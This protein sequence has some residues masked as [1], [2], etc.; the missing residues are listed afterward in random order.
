MTTST[1]NL[2]SNPVFRPVADRWL[3]V[4]FAA[5]IISEIWVFTQRDE[6][7]IGLRVVAT[8]LSLVASG[9]LSL[10]RTRPALAFWI[11]GIAVYGLI[12]FGYPSDIYQWTN[13]IA[14]YSVAAHGTRPQSWL[15]LPAAIAGP[16]FYFVRF[17]FMGGPALAAFVAAMWM[18]GWLAGRMA[19]VRV[20]ESHLRYERDLSMQLAQANQER[21][22][23]EEERNLIARELHDIIGHTVNVMVVHA[24]AGR[25]A[26]PDDPEAAVVA[27][28]TIEETGRSALDE[29]DRVLAVLR[30]D[31]LEAARVPTPGLD[32]LPSLATTFS[33]AG[34]QVEVEMRGDTRLVPASVGLAAYRIVQEALTNTLKHASA[35]SASVE[36]TV[37]PDHVELSVADDGERDPSTIKPGRGIT[38]MGERAALH[39]GWARVETGTDGRFTV[40]S[41]LRWDRT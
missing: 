25:G 33:D 15:A 23:V 32:G 9:A 26:L 3:A 19:R 24:G 40:R 29:L 8:L 7:G 36:V 6:Y 27:F 38:G 31:H 20:E 18:V 10:R 4:V 37:L 41:V 11:N 14:T 35:A 28:E 5:L 12:A 1:T 22:A 30:R 17:P 2:P 39:R 13:L 21:L 34:L 16:V